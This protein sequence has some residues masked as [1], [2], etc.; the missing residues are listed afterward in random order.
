MTT[1]TAIIRHA[2][3]GEHYRA[4]LDEAGD[5]ARLSAPLSTFIA[6]NDDTGEMEWDGFAD[7]ALQPWDD[8]NDRWTADKF[9]V[10]HRFSS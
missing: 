5:C 10:V 2:T 8:D 9:V 4:E 6:R 3:S 7:A 1:T